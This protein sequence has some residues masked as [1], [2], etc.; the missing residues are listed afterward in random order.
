MQ[1][2]SSGISGK[3]GYY[4]LIARYHEDKLVWGGTA[5][6]FG[7]ERLHFSCTDELCLHIVDMTNKLTDTYGFTNIKA[8]L[9]NE[10]V[11][12]H[13][14]GGYKSLCWGSAVPRYSVETY[15]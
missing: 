7:V 13:C 15:I 4:D 5:P 8:T 2:T 1:G 12:A 9:Q 6:Q 10:K 3:T 11:E 14:N